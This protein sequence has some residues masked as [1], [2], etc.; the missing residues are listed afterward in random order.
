MKKENENKKKFNNPNFFLI[1]LL[2]SAIFQLAVNAQ[3]TTF[4]YQGRLS[5]SSMQANGTYDLSF[6]VYDAPT[7]GSQI[8]TAITRPAVNVSN[9]VFTVQLDFGANAFPGADRYLQIAVKRPSDTDYTVLIPRQQVT[10]T[11]YS[12]RALNATNAAN[13]GGTAANQFVQTTDSRL[14]DARTPIAGSANYIQ[15]TTTTQTSAN[16]NISGSGTAGGTLSGNAVNSATA[17]TNGGNGKLRIDSAG[18]IL[19]GRLRPNASGGG[20]PTVGGSGNTYLGTGTGGGGFAPPNDNLGFST[21]G[22]NNTLIGANTALGGPDLNYAA[23]IGAGALANFGNTIVLGRTSGEDRVLTYGNIDAQGGISMND[24]VLR[25]RDS[26]DNFH[27][28]AYSPGL[29]GMIFRT[30]DTYQWFNF[31]NNRVNMQL[32]SNGDLAIVGSYLKLSDARYK[33]NVQTIAS[34]LAGIKRLRGVTFN[35]NPE[36]NNSAN[37]IGFIA[38]EVEQVLPELVHTDEKGFKSVAYS[39]AVPVLVEAVKEQQ[40]QIENQQKQID[41][42]KVLIDGLKTLVCSQ[43]PGAVVCK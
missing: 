2:I 35:W 1:T 39:D 28:I 26:G 43:N 11:P 16:F 36:F 14:T 30:F 9:G 21:T 10:S 19:V 41:E 32:T 5:D 23:A 31:R 15:N 4:T 38:Q 40:T 25:L 33:T 20:E 7:G 27:T 13:L 24:R 42:Q 8:G 22:S 29:N 37:Q 12:I 3:T 6:A 34:P 18:N 17:F